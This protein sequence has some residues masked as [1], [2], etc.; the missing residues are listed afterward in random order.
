MSGRSARRRKYIQRGSQGNGNP[1]P[2][3][4][5]NADNISRSVQQGQAQWPAQ[6]PTGKPYPDMPDISAAQAPLDTIGATGTAIFSG[7]ITNEE[8]N[9]DFYWRDAQKIYDQMLRNDGQINAIRQMIELPIRQATWSIEPGSDDPADVEIASFVETC[10]F[11]DMTYTTS[12]G[13]KITQKWDDILRHALMSLWYGFMPFEIDYRVEDGW[14]KWA[15]WTPLLPRTVW[16][17]WVGEDNELVGIQQWTFK[18]YGYQFVNIPVEKL[19]L[20]VYRQEGG[21]FEGLPLLRTAYKHWFY[22]TQ[23]EKI[24]AISMER[25]AVVPP[26]IY[27]PNNFTAADLTQA[28]AIVQNM[29]VNESMGVTLPP[30]WDLMYPKNFAKW[31]SQV[32]PSIQYHDTMIARNVLAQVINLG[33]QE[34]GSFALGETLLSI[35]LRSL[36]TNAKY[37]EQVISLDAIPKLVDYNFENVSVY[38]KLKCSRIQADVTILSDALQKLVNMPTPLLT[39]DAETEDF[40]RSELGLPQAPSGEIEGRNPTKPQQSAK[41]SEHQARLLQ[42]AM[43]QLQAMDAIE[44][45]VRSPERHRH[46]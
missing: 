33:S 6:M 42:E 9:P 14:T 41:A 34:T 8:Y 36:Q 19:L 28:Q 40:L 38:P 37:I 44:R 45:G 20:F 17:W 26:V 27:L 16:R 2:Q 3:R 35:F 46:G 13:H 15:R 43:S 31:A 30:G 24:D 10:L 1:N 4:S 5:A 25:D 11:H 39:P 18:D 12:E 22:K 29:R 32:M 21:N 23:F 7:I